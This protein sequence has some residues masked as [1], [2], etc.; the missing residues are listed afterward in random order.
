MKNRIVDILLFFVLIFYSSGTLAQLNPDNVCRID[1]G[2][3]IFT[4][5]LKWTEKEKKEVSELFDLDSVLLTHVYN[6]E[7]NID[8][9][10]EH[11]KVKKLSANLVELS[12][13]VQ[14]DEPENRFGLDVLFQVIDSWFNFTGNE[15][16]TSTGFGSNDFDNSKV[17]I[18]ENGVARFYLQGF[19]E[20]G[21][22]FISGTFNNWSTSQTPMKF[23]GNG[24][25][26][27][28]KLDPGKYEYKFIVDGSWMTDP[29]NN[30]R[31]RGDAGSDNSV[32]YCYNYVFKLNGF[33]NADK[34]VVTG[35]FSGW[36]PQGIAMKRTSDGWSLPVYFSDG[37]YAYK[38][39][40]DGRWM[41]DPDNPVQRSDAN[42]NIN[43]FIS[44]GTPFTF[45]LNDHI[46]ANKVVL[47]GSFNN[48]NEN[49]LVMD[50]TSTGWQLP[51]VIG[52]GNY[53]YKFIV[54]GN[55]MTDP[56]NP[57]T[58]GSDNYTNSFI[59][60]KA[61]HVFELDQY[62]D[63]SQVIVTGNFNNWST[64][65]YR[66]IKDKGKWI[67]P[68]YLKPGKYV[69]K[70]IVDGNWIIDP[71]NKLFEENGQGTNNSVLWMNNSE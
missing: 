1:K 10:D 34:V 25:A 64:K 3:L 60:L 67:F 52:P 28:L 6:G 2:Q 51:Y 56:D 53:E 68:M 62:L 14:H 27:E 20:A 4:L 12:K 8:Y 41:T 16:E 37:T 48:W 39:L 33:P 11:W 36:K 17:F 19:K 32:V 29:E 59:A 54:D 49:E 21:N 71:K 46:D 58:T 30:L 23:T 35:N 65:D 55:W 38:F 66:M 40:V 50:K 57:F 31:Q 26:I 43:S 7:S 24:W 13:S 69:Y 70:F 22:V 47:T 44:I 45:K 61:N 18:Y 15:V 63:A 9:N 5:N 42:G